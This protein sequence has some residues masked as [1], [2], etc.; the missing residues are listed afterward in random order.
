LR[1]CL[2]LGRTRD[3]ELA[4]SAAKS[5]S[6]RRLAVAVTEGLFGESAMQPCVYLSKREA[7]EA[8]ALQSGAMMRQARPG[9]LDRP[10]R[11]SGNGLRNFRPLARWISNHRYPRNTYKQ[12][13]L[14]SRAMAQRQD[15]AS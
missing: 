8:E 7:E 6:A 2:A 13:S 4:V 3:L 9:L 14:I 5:Q 11:L 12:K 15:L 10:P 1:P